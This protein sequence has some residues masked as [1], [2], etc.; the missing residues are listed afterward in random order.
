MLYFCETT[1]SAESLNDWFEHVVVVYK[2]ETPS[3]AQ[4][5][6]NQCVCGVKV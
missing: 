6:S 5:L 3:I 4:T 1:S 2:G